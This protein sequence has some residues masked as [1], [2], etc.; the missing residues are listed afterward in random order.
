MALKIQQSANQDFMLMQ[1]SWAKQLNPLLASALSSGIIL[2]NVSL[3]DGHTTFLHYLGR[4]MQGW[5]VVDQDAPAEINR[6]STAPMN[7]Q[8][9]TLTS[10]AAV[11]VNLFVF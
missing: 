6:L 2:P 8:S 5:F 11:T 1:N 3:I 9:L 10:S 4:Q 7:T